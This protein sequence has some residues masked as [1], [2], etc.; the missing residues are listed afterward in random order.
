MNSVSILQHQKFAEM[1]ASILS[2]IIGSFAT[3]ISTGYLIGG[4]IAL[5]ILVYLIYSLVK[6][7]K[8]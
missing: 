6:P 7:E 1:S 5:F 3:N 8:F 4:I 2:V